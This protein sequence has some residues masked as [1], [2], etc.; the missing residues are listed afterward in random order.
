MVRTLKAYITNVKKRLI[1]SP[2]ITIRDTGLL[3]ALL[4]IETPDELFGHPIYGSSFESYV[5][6]N[7]CHALPKWNHYFY[8]TSSGTELDLVLEKAGKVVAVEIKASTAAKPSRGFWNAIEDIEAD[9]AYII[10]PVDE[11]YPI[12]KKVMVT[13]V[14]SFLATEA[15]AV[16]PSYSCSR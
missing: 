15:Q 9:R 1:K 2:K 7:I 16:I 12:Q 8:R 3:H 5:V 6:E 11:P 13:N 4:N 10:A 14:A